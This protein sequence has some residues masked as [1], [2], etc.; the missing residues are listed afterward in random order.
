[1]A[2]FSENRHISNLIN[3]SCK[4]GKLSL[5]TMCG[6]KDLFPMPQ[7]HTRFFIIIKSKIVEKSNRPLNVGSNSLFLEIKSSISKA[8]PID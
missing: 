4:V 5:Q 1:M 3:M 6:E 8:V 2:E 7:Q